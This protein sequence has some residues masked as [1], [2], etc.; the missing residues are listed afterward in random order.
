V[1]ASRERWEDSLRR[2]RFGEPRL[3]FAPGVPDHVRDEDSL[4]AN[5]FSMSTSAPP[6]FGPRRQEFEAEL[7]ALALAGPLRRDGGQAAG[8]SRPPESGNSRETSSRAR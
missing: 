4:V 6:R 8:F 3:V 5:V 7:R 2:T 1:D